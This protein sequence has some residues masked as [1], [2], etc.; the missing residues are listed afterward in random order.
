MLK[1]LWPDLR[2]TETTH[3]N[4]CNTY[5][6]SSN[7]IEFAI[8]CMMIEGDVQVSVYLKNLLISQFLIL[9]LDSE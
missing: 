1:S 9:I 3:N 4:Y 5:E 7:R 6:F 2:L 8:L